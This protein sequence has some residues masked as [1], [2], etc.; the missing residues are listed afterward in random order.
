M[1]LFFNYIITNN[2]NM[3]FTRFHDDPNRIR[4]QA[5]ELSYAGKYALNTPGPGDNIPFLE[6]PQVRLQTWGANLMTNTINLESDLRGLT[7]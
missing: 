3:S 4:K 5:A 2:F 7:R 6:D 1:N